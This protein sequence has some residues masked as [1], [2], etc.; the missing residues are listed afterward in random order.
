MAK[1]FRGW[2]NSDAKAAITWT[3]IMGSTSDGLPHVGL[4]PGTQNRWILA[5]FNGGGMALLFTLAKDIADMVV[6]EILFE[7]T[8]IPKVFKTTEQR[9]SAK[10]C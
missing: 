8:G 5:G 2:E 7:Q 6:N 10:C 9:I 3:G 4:V 1:T